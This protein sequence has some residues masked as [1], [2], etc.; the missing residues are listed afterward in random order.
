VVARQVRY[1]ICYSNAA[2]AGWLRAVQSLGQTR[3][4]SELESDGVEVGWPAEQ[5]MT[6]A[7]A[8]TELVLLP[9][10]NLWGSPRERRRY[11]EA[12]SMSIPLGP[13]TSVSND[14]GWLEIRTSAD[15]VSLKS[16]YQEKRAVLCRALRMALADRKGLS[17]RTPT[18]TEQLRELVGMHESGACSGPA[19]TW[20]ISAQFASSTGC[21]APSRRSTAR[22]N[23][24]AP[25]THRDHGYG[26]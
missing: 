24:R 26:A 20:R 12:D 17:A 11:H 9:F 15:H 23:P 19:T 14:V 2:R 21:P 6:A 5:C 4:D 13:V 18:P 22:A 1:S 8:P 3:A 10:T 25:T 7:L 16:S